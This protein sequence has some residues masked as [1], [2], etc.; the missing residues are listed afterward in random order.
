MIKTPISRIFAKLEVRDRAQAVIAAYQ[1]GLVTPGARRSWPAYRPRTTSER[2]AKPPTQFRPPR[3]A[4]G[5]GGALHRRV[6]A[7]DRERALLAK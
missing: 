5:W 6:R 4:S 3:G 2:S 7:R 1:A